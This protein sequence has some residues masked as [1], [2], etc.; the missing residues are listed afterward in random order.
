MPNYRVTAS[1]LRLRS[2]PGTNYETIGM[3][4]RNTIVV[5]DEVNGDWV[6]VTTE[7]NKVGWSH[8]GYLEL[9][10]EPPP[11]TPGQ[12]KY[13]VDATS[14]YLRQG[15]GTNFAVV[16]TLKKSDSSCKPPES[17]NTKVAPRIA[18]TSWS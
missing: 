8:R 15:P 14:L 10:A 3:L 6:H 17:L 16:G 11:P 2:G 9:L 13:R 18:A 4:L 1:T 5:G 12:E 7:D